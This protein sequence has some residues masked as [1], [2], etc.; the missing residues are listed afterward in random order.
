[1][2]YANVIVD[3][4]LEKLDRTFQYRVPEELEDAL[5]VGM[6]VLVPFGNG[7]RRLTAY[8]VELTEECEWDPERV[9]E[10][11]GIAERGIR[12]EGQLIALASWMRRVYG[13]TMNQALK[14]VL[15]VRRAVQEK[16]KRRIVLAVSGKEAEEYREILKRKNQKARLRLLEAL[17]AGLRKHSEI[18]SHHSPDSQGP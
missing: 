18:T 8:V 3:I 2:K 6:Q 16:V 9:K 4:S 7:S 5:S 10:I 17:L 1:M 13:S 15:P 12:L 14:T 11:I